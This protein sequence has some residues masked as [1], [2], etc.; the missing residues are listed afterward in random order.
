MLKNKIPK[1]VLLRN[2]ILRGMRLILPRFALMNPFKIVFTGLF[3]LFL[4]NSGA[5][6]Q[7]TLDEIGVNVGGGMN[8]LTGQNGSLV[9]WGALA[10]GYYSHYFCGKRHGFHVEGGFRYLATY[11][12]NPVFTPVA[13]PG[14][15][16]KV[17]AGI[18]DAGFLGKIRKNEYHRPRE[19]ALMFGPKINVNLFGKFEEWGI[20]GPLDQTPGGLSIF[21]V[22]LQLSA[23]IRRKFDKNSWFI[24]PGVEYFFLPTLPN[25]MMGNLSNLHIFLQFGVNLW[26]AKG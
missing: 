20:S 15:S 18:L 8:V 13:L 16:N 11:T 17:S 5:K 21:N 10:K 14:A 9:G 26:D 12:E 19:T 3:L 1:N 24:H 7:F 4:A 6:A 2:T 23:Q 25:T 22:G